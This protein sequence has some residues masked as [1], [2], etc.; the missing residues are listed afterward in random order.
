MGVRIVLPEHLGI[1][2]GIAG[3][4]CTQPSPGSNPG[5][6]TMNR[7]AAAGYFGGHPSGGRAGS[8]PADLLRRCPRSILGTEALTVMQRVLTPQSSVRV[9]AVPPA[10]GGEQRCSTGLE[11]RAGCMAEGST[12]SLSSTEGWQSGNAPGSYPEAGLTATE[13]RT[14]HPPPGWAGRRSPTSRR[15][16]RRPQRG[17]HSR[18]VQL[19]AHLA[20]NQ[21][22]GVRILTREPAARNKR[23]PGGP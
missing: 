9:V 12:P 7:C 16:A 13:V 2:L 5:V 4:V 19:G 6:S 14:F 21:E 10:E 3:M 1:A 8:N 18:V 22:I 17:A 20:L 11:S 15:P 23:P